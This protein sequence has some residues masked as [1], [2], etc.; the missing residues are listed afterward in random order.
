[1]L[2]KPSKTN[3]LP[4]IGVVLVL[5]TVPL[6]TR[7]VY[8]LSLGGS[9]FVWAAAATAWNISAGFAGGLSLGHAAFFGIGAYTAALLF[10]K[11]GIT[12]WVGM[13]AGVVI[14]GLIG[15]FLG[16]ITFRL[17]GPFFVLATLAF[18]IVVHIIA[19]NWRSLTRGSAGLNLPFDG[20]AANMLFRDMGTYW[21][22][23][24]ILLALC[25]AVSAWIEK[26]RL[27]YYLVAL[28][29]NEEA[30]YSLGV[31]VVQSKVSA[32]AISAGLTALAGSF[33]A[34]FIQYIDPA[35]T[36]QFELSVQIALIAI[37]GGVGTTIGPFLGAA[38]IVPLGEVL[39]AQ[40]GGG[41]S[42]VLYGFLLM[43]IVLAAPN[44]AIA[45]LRVLR[46]KFRRR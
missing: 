23:G 26:S 38:I 22:V 24:L 37:V 19:V 5:L 6:L 3:L 36:T 42:L 12:P 8:W 17:R 39:R 4:G 13:L 34:F 7:D 45:G 44:G 21:H 46:R 30:A 32:A 15:A 41:P 1:M 16:A 11:L 25:L 10:L 29:E 27:G 40:L 9:V 33:Y 31:K 20:G 14:A 2:P 18:G 28:R 43:L 35:S